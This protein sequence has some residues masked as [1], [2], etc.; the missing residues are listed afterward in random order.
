MAMEAAVAAA[1]GRE[2]VTKGAGEGGSNAQQGWRNPQKVPMEAAATVE[3]TRG[4]RQH[5]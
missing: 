5:M 3:E 4:M 1:D 2:H